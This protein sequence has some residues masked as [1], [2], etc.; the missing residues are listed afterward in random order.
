[1]PRADVAAEAEKVFAAES[2][3]AGIRVAVI[4][5][6]SIVYA[7]GVDKAA[8]L[9][10]LAWSVIVT[11]NVYGLG[12]WALRP[13]RR[14][15]VMLSS[16]FTTALDAVFITVWL[17][18]TGGFESPFY[19]L[20]MLSVTAVAFRYDARA[21]LFAAGVY[22]LCYLG[23]LA[24]LGEVAGHGWDV[25]TRLGYL[26]LT[27]ALG[28]FLSR[29]VYAQTRAKVELQE[30]TSA[31]RESR[32]RFQRL[33]D[34]TFEGIAIHEQGRI[35][36]T[37]ASFA[38]M[39]GYAPDDL[40]GMAADRL[41]DPV[42]LPALAEH[43][44]HPRDEP[45]LVVARR[46]DGSTFDA[47]I[48]ARDLPWEGRTVRVVALR[49]VTERKKAEHAVLEREALAMQNER[50]R[51]MDALK[52]SFINNAAHEL[53]TPLTPIKLQAHL[54]RLGGMGELNDKQ[55]RA[56]D[57][58][59]RNVDHLGLMVKDLLDASR[60]QSQ[61]LRL[62]SAPVDLQATLAEAVEAFSANATVDIRLATT[63]G[64]HIE[65]DAQRVKQVVFNLLGNALKFTPA[66]GHI[67]VRARREGAE[68]HVE[69]ADTGSGIAPEDIEKLF[70]PF[71][72]VHDTTTTSRAGTGLGLFI[73]KGIV[74][75]HGGRIWATSGGRGHGT[76][77][78][79]TLPVEPVV[80]LRAPQIP[81]EG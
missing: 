13:Y 37:N 11:A 46:R 23:L 54:L 59:S 43:L 81:K 6:N 29:E 5:L 52:T 10:P 40:V 63:P 66:G 64:L 30:V 38:A 16:Y 22:A 50:L 80:V 68:V 2:A 61:E 20:W 21:T 51:E 28:G 49:D 70:R 57:V 77:F 71:S 48:T 3:I 12:V 79:F 34:A 1:M 9:P 56:V 8:T 58:L 15:P 55:K 27:A 45:W 74:E 47:E 31:L 24:A 72:Q 18:A 42:S 76:T 33:S 62:R 39:M 25:A 35:L 67:D 78:H 14:F 4:A 65:G 32:E 36:E 26:F 19:L 17:L 73:S 44:A 53:G 60:V 75:S 41:V 69:I 7:F